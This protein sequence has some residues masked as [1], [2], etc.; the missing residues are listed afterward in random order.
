MTCDANSAASRFPQSRTAFT[1]NSDETVSNPKNLKPW[2]KGVSGNP[3]GRPKLKPL[4][5][6]LERLLEQEAPKSKGQTWAAVIAEA[7]VKRASKGDVRAIAELG[8]RI[9]GRPVQAVELD[10]N[11]NDSIVERL[12]AGLRRVLAGMTDEEIR[13]KIKQL[14]AQLG[15]LDNENAR[16]Q[17]ENRN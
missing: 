8:N 11:L 14:E 17:T 13:D 6:E 5:E 4:T 1:Q 3:G 12:Q 10:A 2:P 7:L 15:D 9:E 16:R